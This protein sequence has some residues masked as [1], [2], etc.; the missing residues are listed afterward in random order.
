MSVTLRKRTNSDGTTTLRLDIL[1]NGQRWYE[2]LKNL[3][4]SKPTTL[5]LRESN[6]DLLRQAEQIRTSRAA[7]L[8][9]GNYGMV[10]DKGKRQLVI[11]WLDSYVD[12]YTKEDKRVMKAVIAEFSKFLQDEGEEKITFSALTSNLLE[13]FVGQLN[14]AHTGEGASTYYRRLK[15]AIRHAYKQKLMHENITDFVEVKA[16]SKADDRDILTLDEIQEL[17]K[18]PIQSPEVR[19]AAIS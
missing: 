16:N 18:T 6:K 1:H 2:A 3:K 15:K 10:S 5:L 12:K 17:I 11:Q 14:A 8:E 7:E 13:N 19:K 9:A 4:L